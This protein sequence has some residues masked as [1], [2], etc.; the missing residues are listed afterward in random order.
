MFRQDPLNTIL[1]L[2]SGFTPTAVRMTATLRLPDLVEQGHR[3]V[4]ALAAETG[5]DEQS[6]G[7]VLHYV[8]LLGL[9]SEAEAPEGGEKTY[10]LTDVGRVLLSDHPSNLR[11]WLDYEDPSRAMEARFEPA[12]GRLMDAVRTGLPVYE[13]AHGRPFWADLE[14]HPDIEKSFNAGIARIAGRLV[15]E[16]ARIYDWASVKHVVDVG[17]GNGSLLLKL[18]TEHPALRGTLLELESVIEEAKGTTA[19]VADRCELVPGSFFEPMPAGGDVYLIANTLHNWS[20]RDAVRI[21][22]RCAEALEAGGRVVVVERLLDSGKDP[23][24]ASYADL[25]MLVLLGGRERSLDDLRTLGGEVGLT[26]TDAKKFELP[27]HWLIEFTKG[28]TR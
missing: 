7:R 1:A 3:S 25:L 13:Q 21:L 11:R 16:L 12:I 20:D 6:L 24:M 4:A 18:L 19:Q 23:V 22:G 9:F 2:G 27:G 5:T 8:S 26:L 10:E 28:E 14:A 17:G 15:P